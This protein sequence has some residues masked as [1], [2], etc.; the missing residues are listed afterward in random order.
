M[1]LS[2]FD[3]VAACLAHLC[4]RAK[5]DPCATDRG[6]AKRVAA[7]WRADG[8]FAEGRHHPCGP[9]A[10]WVG[11]ASGVVGDPG[12]RESVYALA[13]TAGVRL[14]HPGGRVELVPWPPVVARAVLLLTTAGNFRDTG[15]A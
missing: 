2:P 8:A 13:T 6:S 11:Q 1:D 14:R 4:R 3:S 12:D 10:W 9:L 5:V 15:A 7:V